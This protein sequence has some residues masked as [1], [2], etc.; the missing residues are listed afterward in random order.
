MAVNKK[1]ICVLFGGRAVEHEISMI[2]GLQLIEALDTELYSVVPVYIAHSGK[3][4]TG[5][6]LLKKDFYKGLPG[7]LN[8]LK[9]VTL[10]PKPGI[11]GL[12]V[13]NSPGTSSISKIFSK[14]ETVIPVDVFIPSFHGQFG[15]DGCIQ[16]LFEIADVTYAGS[17]VLASSVA[18]NKAVCKAVA[19][20]HGIPVLPFAIVTKSES[21]KGFAALK[22]KIIATPGLG[23][24]P[25]FIKPNHLG[26]S[27]GISKVKSLA[28]IDG[29]LAGVFKY[30]EQAIV[31]PCVNDIMEINVSVIDGK[32]LTASVVEIPVGTGG[33]LSYED[34]YLKGG[35]K[36]GK[37]QAQSEGMAGLT[38]VIDPKD[39]DPE[40]KNSV[41]NYALKLSSVLGSSGVGRYDF[42]VDTAKNKIYFN[43]LNPIP[44]SFSF[45]LWEKSKPPLIYPQLLNRIIDR[46][47]Q[48]KASL[49]SFE[50]DTGFKALFK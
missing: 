35:G 1:N 22:E 36:K 8:N 12:T 44:G 40:I 4:Y 16:G 20:Q 15:E 46:A 42:I 2:S 18:M 49:S 41:T 37:Q 25:L 6:E 11:G 10:L 28:D 39:L 3:W 23:E 5:K 33:V 19:A 17:D 50:K 14:A 9:E 45:Y 32:E 29:A 26:S 24:F 38:R 30:D 47:I 13:L 48:K 21:A 7:C 27:I 43:E 34:K 31:E